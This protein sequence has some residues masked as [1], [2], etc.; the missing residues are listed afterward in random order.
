[1]SFGE[2]TTLCPWKLLAVES[3]LSRETVCVS[4]INDVNQLQF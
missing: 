2:P 3:G 4:D 1:M